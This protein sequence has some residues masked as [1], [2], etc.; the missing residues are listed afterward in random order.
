VPRR[1][2][3]V[4]VEKRPVMTNDPPALQTD[5]AGVPPTPEADPSGVP[6]LLTISAAASLTGLSRKALTRRIER[7]SLRAVKDER[8]RRVVPRGEL[9]RAELLNP[10]GSPGDE[11]YPGGELVIWRN[12]YEHERQEREEAD[13]H[14]RELEHDLIAIANAGPIRALGLRRQLR[15]KLAESWPGDDS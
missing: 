7:G 13:A 6:R 15:E 10:D 12:L 14:A 5:P 9:E 2:Y 4:T 8:G 11:G 1:G 3:L